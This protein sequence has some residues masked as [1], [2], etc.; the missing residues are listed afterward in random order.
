MKARVAK[1][2]RAAEQRK[3]SSK[4]S[5]KE[6]KGGV[7]RPKIRPRVKNFR[8]K[9]PQYIKTRDLMIRRPVNEASRWFE[10]GIWR[11]VPYK[12][13]NGFFVEDEGR[14]MR[15]VE[16]GYIKRGI[17]IGPAAGRCPFDML[18]DE[19]LDGLIK[20][21]LGWKNINNS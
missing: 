10:T 7:I 18:S 20:I 16:T 2:L 1:A 19:D 9:R 12:E 17:S 8:L 15:F 5:L 13:S 3:N 14:I 21:S 11:Y 4:Q 6:R